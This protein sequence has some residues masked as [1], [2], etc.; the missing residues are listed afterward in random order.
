MYVLYKVDMYAFV[1][2]RYMKKTLIQTRHVRWLTLKYVEMCI[3]VQVDDHFSNNFK[4]EYLLIL[5]S[6]S[7]CFAVSFPNDCSIIDF[8]NFATQDI[9]V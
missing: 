6:F 3:L 1:N 7:M 5:F 2:G 8:T 4:S 9:Q